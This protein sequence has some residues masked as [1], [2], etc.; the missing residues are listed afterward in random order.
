MGAT[1]LGAANCPVCNTTHEVHD[2]AG[3]CCEDQRDRGIND[4]IVTDN[5]GKGRVLAEQRHDYVRVT[6]VTSR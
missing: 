1:P 4:T 3:F 5:T 2:D 6:M